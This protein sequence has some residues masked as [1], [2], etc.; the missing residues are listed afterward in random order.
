MD[1]TAA[2]LEAYRDRIV[3]IAEPKRGRSPPAT[4]G[5]GA[6]PATSWPSLT[7]TVSS[8]RAWLRHL[9]RPLA[10]ESVGVA[11]GTIRARLPANYVS[12]FGE[13][14][15]DHRLAI[16]VYKPPYAATMNWASR[17]A[18]LERVGGFDEAF[19]RCE[20]VDL[21]YRLQQSGYS[22]IYV[23]DALIY[24]HHR[25]TLR[26]LF[27]EGFLHGLYAV[28]TMKSH[29]SF[30]ASFGHQRIDPR[31][32]LGILSSGTRAIRGRDRGAACECV[33]NVG[34]K[35]GKITGSFRFAYVDL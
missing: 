32:Y 29:R 33:F 7:P 5:S 2:V 3:V 21:A 18:V 8:T 13:R 30:V 19:R 14:I 26:G 6:R 24:H 16:T 15:H 23:P 11:A 35:L 25:T 31:T 12:A 28:Q 4:R 9:V 17:R 22:L 1:G 20:D 10:D 34:K 27:C